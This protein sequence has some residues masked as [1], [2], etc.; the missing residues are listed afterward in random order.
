M[1]QNGALRIMII[2]CKLEYI[3]KRTR[4]EQFPENKRWDTH[5]VVTH[6]QISPSPS[7]NLEK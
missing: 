4:F 6:Q 5:S 3:Q 2:M 1:E 7:Q